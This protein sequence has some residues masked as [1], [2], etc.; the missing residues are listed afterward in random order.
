MSYLWIQN[1]YHLDIVMNKSMYYENKILNDVMTSI[2]TEFIKQ[3]YTELLEVKRQNQIY[4][5]KIIGLTMKHLTIAVIML[6]LNF[7]LLFFEL[8]KRKK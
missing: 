6:V 3:K 5:N 4:K 8:H 2:D 1:S 7:I